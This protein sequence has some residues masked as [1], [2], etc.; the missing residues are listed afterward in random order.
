MG[1]GVA[2]DGEVV[3]KAAHPVH[4]ASQIAL[5]SEPLRYV[6]RGGLKLAHALQE[7]NISP[8]GKT[9]LDVG[10]STGGFTD[11]LLQNGASRVYA[12]DVGYGQL[13]WTLRNDPRVV[14]MERTNIRTLSG[15]P[16]SVDLAV[17]D[18][19]FISLRQ[20]LPPVRALLGE[21]GRVIALVKPQFEAGRASVRKGV[22][23]DPAVWREVLANVA[24]YARDNRLAAV[25]VTRSPVQGPAGNVE[26]LMEMV[27]ARGGQVR[28]LDDEITRAAGS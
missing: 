25:N 10:A 17:I 19:S 16:E 28:S 23:R 5:V 15:L 18:T 12:V 7:F 13:A 4:A 2:V 21:E 8:V 22:V 11:V 20:V 9:A 6:S 26:F 1:G 27:P 14:V 24:D 3:T